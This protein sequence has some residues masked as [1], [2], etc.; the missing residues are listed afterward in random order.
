VSADGQWRLVERD[1]LNMRNPN[2]FEQQFELSPDGTILA[3]GDAFGIV[4]LHLATGTTTRV[5]TRLKDPVLHSWTGPSR[6]V[7]VTERGGPGLEK[8]WEVT[9]TGTNL[10]VPFDPW[11]SAVGTDGRIVE[12]SPAPIE[13]RS[14]HSFTDVRVWRDGDLV[15][16]RPLK[17]GVP[18][19]ARV[20]REWSSVVGIRQHRSK[21]MSSAGGLGVLNPRTGQMTGFLPLPKQPLSWVSMQGPMTD[22]WL[23]LSI[24]FG[25]GGGIFAWDPVR[26]QLR[27]VTEIEEQAASVSLAYLLLSLTTR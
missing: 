23:M 22:R 25:V 21:R 16:T 2:M 19:E 10:R 26:Q 11:L 18:Q 27:A 15:S 6:G 9:V 7:L 13:P 5:V 20:A 4:F 1:L 14:K 8:A 3:L 17:S 24:P 12:F